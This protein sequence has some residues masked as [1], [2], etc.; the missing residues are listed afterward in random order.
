MQTATPKVEIRIV[1]PRRLTPTE[2]QILS[3]LANHEGV[4]CTKAEIAE[5]L[6]RNR[7]TIDRLV[8]NLRADGL[9]ISEP[10][11]GENGRQLAN[12]YRLG[13]TR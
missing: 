2:R 11:W 6:G 4:P 10:S 13:G 12:T 7:K 9:L 3:F 1:A 8:S 5:A